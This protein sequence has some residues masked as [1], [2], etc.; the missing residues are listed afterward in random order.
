[1][2]SELFQGFTQHGMVLS[3]QHFGTTHLQASSNPSMPRTL[4]YTVYI[5]NG[6]GSDWL[7]DNVMPSNGVDTA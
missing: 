6:V 5:G 4:R 3:Y 2:R 1:M 7:S